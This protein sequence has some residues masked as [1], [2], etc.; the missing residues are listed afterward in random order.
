M[1]IDFHQNRVCRSVKTVHTNLF[2]QYRKLH[3]FATTNS[4]LKKI[5]F[6]DIHHH[7]KYLYINFQH[8][9]VKTQVMTVPTR[10]Y[11]LPRKEIIDIDGQTDRQTYTNKRTRTDGQTD[12]RTDGQTSR[13]TTFFS[14]EKKM[15]KLYINF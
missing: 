6:L 15:L 13:V 12:G 11:K 7:K 5:F 4:N 9:L 1:Y 2:T 10:Y 3:E 8:N 14:E